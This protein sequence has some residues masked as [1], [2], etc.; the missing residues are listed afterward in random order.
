MSSA[1]PVTSRGVAPG[2][3]VLIAFAM[4]PVSSIDEPNEP[5]YLP[6]T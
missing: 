4:K 1:L 2:K 6:S 5:T 3:D